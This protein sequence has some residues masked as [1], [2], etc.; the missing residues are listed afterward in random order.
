MLRINRSSLSSAP[1]AMSLRYAL[2]TALLALFLVPAVRA[3]TPYDL[4]P[5]PDGPVHT[6]AV[7][8]DTLFFGGDFDFIGPRVGPATA[9]DPVTGE[10]VDGVIPEIEIGY[11]GSA[12]GASVALADGAGGVFLGGS[13]SAAGGLPRTNLAHILPDG[14]VNPDFAPDPVY[15]EGWPG[16][17]SRLVLADTV[18]LVMGR[19]SEM[20]GEPRED[21]AAVDARTGAV[22]DLTVTLTPE[23][24]DYPTG[25]GSAVLRDSV[26]LVSG[27]FATIN[28]VARPGLAALDFATG[29][30]LAWDPGLDS[31]GYVSRLIPSED[32]VY[33]VGRFE[34]LGGE[35]RDGMAEIAYPAADDAGP[36]LTDWAPAFALADRGFSYAPIDDY[37]LTDDW[38]WLVGMFAEESWPG[39]RVF[40]TLIRFPRTADAVHAEPFMGD[41]VYR[42]GSAI[43]TDG[44]TVW[45]SV[46]LDLGGI[47]QRGY[48]LGVDAE[49][50]EPT[51]FEVLTGPIESL[52]GGL[53]HVHGMAFV[54]GRLIVSGRTLELGGEFAP[55]YGAVDLTTGDM[56]PEP[57]EPFPSAL[58]EMVPFPDGHR[59]YYRE[60]LGQYVEIDLR[61]GART[62]FT[63]PY[64]NDEIEPVRDASEAPPVGEPVYTVRGNVG[65]LAAEDR[66]YLESDLGP[67]AQHRLR[68]VDPQT[69]EVLPSFEFRYAGSTL[70]DLVLAD[71]WLYISG[72]FEEV[73][74][75]SYRFYVRVDPET[76]EL[77][78]TW[79]PTPAQGDAR[80]GGPFAFADSLFVIGGENLRRIFGD[81]EVEGLAAFSRPGGAWQPWN[82]GIYGS[83]VRHLQHGDGVFYAAGHLV[84]AN[85]ED[86]DQLAAFDL[87]GNLLDWPAEQPGSA[88]GLLVSE[89]HGRVF[90]SG[91]GDVGGGRENLGSFPAYGS[92]P[93]PVAGEPS[94]APPDVAALSVY[95]NPLRGSAR[96]EMTLPSA[97]TARVEVYD[98]LGRRVAVLHDGRLD[99]G[100]HTLGVDAQ[101]LAPG[102]YIIRMRAEDI[103]LSRRMTV[104]R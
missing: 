37:V 72:S 23:I 64:Y 85:G 17:V 38:L 14:S 67:Q 24:P 30:V 1:A 55:F 12:R 66:L 65:G 77:D 11:G 78:P 44:E 86:R 16:S 94:A 56:L 52:V 74:Y 45:I 93:P 31:T 33:V 3:Q 35:E 63:I 90:V 43:A 2:T 5:I 98:V 10:V 81:N 80:S 42:N 104:L 41:F 60:G 69:L 46:S 92:E 15:N 28:G 75:E 57:A 101:S 68:A 89:R 25:I 13:I 59:L 99:G 29:E 102:V 73:N 54:D 27:S 39:P 97:G 48:V 88:V 61:T 79:T 70:S 50:A 18:L 8:E 34:S 58:S 95:P 76:G 36:I 4:I 53:P 84:R 96:L 71:G 40:T 51:E 7:I 6:M 47:D 103:T 19:F 91:A 62:P 100:T 83:L 49:T 20:A 32:G 22:F 26:L 9:L 82:G 21:F 87:D